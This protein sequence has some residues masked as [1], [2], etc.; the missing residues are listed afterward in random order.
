M[1]HEEAG[2]KHAALTHPLNSNDHS[3]K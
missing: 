3:E 1:N 2:T